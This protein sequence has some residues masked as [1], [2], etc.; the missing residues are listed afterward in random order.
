MRTKEISK[1]IPGIECWFRCRK[2]RN[3]RRRLMKNFNKSNG[4]GGSGGYSEQDG[5]IFEE[6]G[7]I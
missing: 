4:I 1:I 6:R 7:N 5:T 2:Y 3:G